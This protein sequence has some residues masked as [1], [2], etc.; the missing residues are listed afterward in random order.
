MPPQHHYQPHQNTNFEHRPNYYD[1]NSMNSRFPSDQNLS[2]NEPE[3]I[4]GEKHNRIFVREI[5]LGGI[6]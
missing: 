4:V 6:P 3:K 1:R 2:S 5:W